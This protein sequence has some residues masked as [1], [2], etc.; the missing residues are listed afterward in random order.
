[1]VA[2]SQRQR[3]PRHHAWQLAVQAWH[4]CCIRRRG[5]APCPLQALL[6]QECTQHPCL[7]QTYDWGL[8]PLDQPDPANPGAP[9][10]H[11]LWVVLQLCNRGSLYDAV[12]KGRFRLVP[13]DEHSGPSM[14][15][16]L[17]TAHEIAGA[18][19]FS[20]PRRRRDLGSAARMA[21]ALPHLSRTDCFTCRS[22]S[23]PRLLAL[24][25]PTVCLQAA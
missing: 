7:V 9:V 6:G 11:T 12:L 19:V 14:L 3:R 10:R 13:S 16:I 2:A 8:R 23:P 20:N 18:P 1:M 17:Q 24:L 22:L 21:P 4:R 5:P 15:A 25:P